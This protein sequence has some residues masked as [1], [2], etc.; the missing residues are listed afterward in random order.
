MNEAEQTGHVES[1]PGIPESIQKLPTDV[2][3]VSDQMILLTWLAF[4]IAALA[5]HKLLWRPILKAVESREQSI[6]EALAGAEQAREQLT[7]DEARGRQIME[8]AADQA[9]VSAEQAARESSAILARADQ[10]A[11]A[12]AQRRL[13]EAE[14]EIEVETDKATEAVRLETA[15]HIGELVERLLLTSLTDEQRRAYQSD[16][17]SEV[18]L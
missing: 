4:G 11:K 15:K 2:M 8:E 9:R 17:L 3:H 16:I 18:T 14:R 12:V 6:D 13:L 7:A 5:L 1:V 10:E